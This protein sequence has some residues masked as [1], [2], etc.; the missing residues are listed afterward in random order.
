MFKAIFR[1]WN[2]FVWSGFVARGGRDGKDGGKGGL[3]LEKVGP[4]FSSLN[5]MPAEIT[6]NIV[7]MSASW[8]NL[9]DIFV[10][11][12]QEHLCIGKGTSVYVMDPAHW[13]DLKQQYPCDILC[14]V[15]NKVQKVSRKKRIKIPGDRC[16]LKASEDISPHCHNL[17]QTFVWWGASSPLIL[18]RPF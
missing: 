18:K 14:F 4:I 5:A 7:M 17:L 10:M 6:K 12:L 15:T 16:I 9:F 13:I 1:Y 3:K 8:W 11:T 2:C